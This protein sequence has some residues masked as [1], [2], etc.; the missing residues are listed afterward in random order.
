MGVTSA[1]LSLISGLLT[2]AMWSGFADAQVTLDGTLN[3][4]VSQNGNNFT[5]TNGNRVGNNLFHSFNQFSIPSNGS[6][7]FNNASDIQ[8]IFS[9][10]TGGNISS[11]D[12][13]I[14]ANGSA[15]LFLLNPTGIVFGLNAKLDIGGSFLGSTASSIKFADGTEFS[16]ANPT[17]SPLLTMSVPIGLQMGQASGAITVQG[18]GHTLTILDSLGAT[19]FVQPTHP[20]LQV[21]PGKT[22]ALVGSD[23]TLKNGVLGAVQGRLEVGSVANGVVSLDTT[24]P[25]W[26]LGYADISGFGDVRLM[27]RSL[28]DVSGIN[29]GSIQ[30]QGR[31]I[32]LQDGSV[33]LSQ[34]QG[35]RT[36]GE[37]RVNA[38]QGLQVSGT[39]T[40]GIIRSGI[41]SETLGSGAGGKIVI[42][43]PILQV[44]QGGNIGART[45]KQGV[46]GDIQIAASLLQV[47]GV[48]AINPVQASSIAATTF[49]VAN[50]GNVTV[51]TKDLQLFDGA[52][53]ATSTFGIGT[54]GQ[55]SV[56]S[57]TINISRVSPLG[58]PSALGT[59]SFGNGNSGRLTINTRTLTLL[60]GGALPANAYA[61]GNAGNIIV[62][63]SESIE[64]NGFTDI[65][66]DRNRSTINS[67]VQIPSLIFRQLLKLSD[68]PSGMAGTVEINTPNLTL[69]NEGA[70][71]VK[72]VGTGQ[73]GV[74]MITADKIRLSQN[75]RLSAETVSGTGGYINLQTNLLTLRQ[76]SRIFANADNQGDGGNIK[77]NAPIILGLEN[78]DIIANAI[79][80]KGGNIQI[81]TQGIIGLKYRPQLT[82]ENDITAS[83]QFGVNGTV[84]VNN[85]GIDPNSGLVELPANVTDPSQQIA[86]SCSAN[87]G[88][89]FVATGR[90]GVPQNPTQEVRSDRPWSDVRNLNA[91]RQTGNI[92]TQMPISPD[93]LI[94]ATS[95]HRNAN[96]KVELV[97]NQPTQIQTSLTCAA[98]SN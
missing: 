70:I 7:F 21:K 91:Y 71:I 39:T 19:P 46:G 35:L 57:D 17:T 90:G 24:T 4:T 81:T 23:V 60:D 88:S 40:N 96:G 98:V 82:P 78:S 49:G 79:K 48:S 92:T 43:T 55:I 34:N 14:K 97:V 9:R 68:L 69:A 77:I 73:G 30:V 44:Q 67:S 89:R 80:G 75:S 61:K 3:T 16:V 87:Q 22:L 84:Q 95:W 20:G 56:T 76:G 94:Q 28:L 45:F 6:A 1:W 59:T 42:T 74:L 93:I 85:I 36:G 31:Q 51:T 13:L 2:G 29:A 8:N 33:L 58:A 54:S 37:I 65:L 53:V 11:I 63:A 86:S 18:T 41:N 72:N 32:T 52:T 27:G 66:Q 10:V 26:G 12:G 25:S 64:V 15:N 50:S 38:S 83:S 5:I 62:N 47:Q